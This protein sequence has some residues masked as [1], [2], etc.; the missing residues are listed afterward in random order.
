MLDEFY[1]S[2]QSRAP[3]EC[4]FV[5]VG[6]KIVEEKERQI[7]QEEAEDYSQK[8]GAIKY[9]EIPTLTGEGIKELFTLIANCPDLH[10]EEDIEQSSIS[11]L[12]P[13][14]QKKKQCF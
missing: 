10:Y 8:I 4:I 13:P 6:N 2:L 1:D 12:P 5:L 11:D 14:E 7:S 3:V 9:V